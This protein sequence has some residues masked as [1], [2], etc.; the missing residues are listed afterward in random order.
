MEINFFIVFFSGLIV[1]VAPCIL[2]MLSTFGSSLVLIEEKGKFIKISVGLLFGIVLTYILISIAFLYFIPFFKAFSFFKYIFA[3]VLVFL[4]AWQIA[5]CKKE[6]SIIFGTPKKVKKVMKT[7]IEKNSGFYAFLVGVIF[8]LIK[9]PC[10]GSVYIALLVNLY[11]NPLLYLYIIVY[12]LGMTIPIIIILCLL[13]LGLES[14]KIDEFRL[15]YRTPLRIL[16]GAILIF[17]AFY[18]LFLADL[19]TA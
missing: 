17:L 6:H 15:K 10:F 3:G 2:L 7:F 5:E 1:G 16:S 19:I 4:G 8:V 11:L 9:I 13:R 14:S 12:L 18:L